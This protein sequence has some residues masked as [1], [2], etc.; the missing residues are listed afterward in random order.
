[1]SHPTDR[2]YTY[3]GRNQ[4]FIK[5]RSVPFVSADLKRFTASRMQPAK[6]ETTAVKIGAGE[7]CF[8]VSTARI[9]FDGFRSVY[10]EAEEGEGREQCTGRT[11]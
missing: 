8:T 11:S 7:Y 3:T 4:G 6:Y 10:V 5:Q 1:M 9:A 2:Y